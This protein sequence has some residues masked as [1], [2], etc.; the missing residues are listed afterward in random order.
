MR[1]IGRH[2]LLLMFVSPFV[3]ARGQASAA[4][5]SSSKPSTALFVTTGASWGNVPIAS[6]GNVQIQPAQRTGLSLG[7]GVERRLGPEWL[8]LR[9]DLGRQ[10]P[11]VANVWNTSLGAL[12]SAERFRL[13]PYLSASAGIYWGDRDD[14]FN[15]AVGVGVRS[16]VGGR[17]I[18]VESRLHNFIAQTYDPSDPRRRFMW[19]ILNFGMLL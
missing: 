14:G 12:I 17:Q 5:Q 19:N 8:T 7:V 4:A 16:S 10:T 6:L 3:A 9:L 18:F 11:G 13:K 15:G 1:Y 2:I